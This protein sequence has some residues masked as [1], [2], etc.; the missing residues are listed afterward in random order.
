MGNAIKMPIYDIMDVD[1]ES[2]I[3]R[4]RTLCVDQAIDTRI[5]SKI[6]HI[7]CGS[8]NEQSYSGKTN[9]WDGN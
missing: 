4:N 7:A 9:Q 6:I 5:E 1:M 3:V 2:L 8:G